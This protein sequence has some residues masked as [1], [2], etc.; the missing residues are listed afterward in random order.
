[1]HF[2]DRLRMFREL[3]GYTQEQLGELVGVAKTTI[4]NYESGK[5]VPHVAKIKRLASALG[6]SGDELLGTGLEEKSSP[7]SDEAYK[8]ARDYDEKLD[9]WGRRTVRSVAD[10][11]IERCE[12]AQKSSANEDGGAAS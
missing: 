6:I 2:G 8:L 4:A 1:M 5:R 3:K 10:H 7:Y 9:E 12:A 11:E